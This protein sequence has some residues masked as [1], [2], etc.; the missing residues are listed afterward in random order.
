MDIFLRFP[1]HLYMHIFLK[2]KYKLLSNVK[3]YSS[4]N[5]I[6]LL[7]ML[8]A[9][10]ILN[11]HNIIFSLG[12]TVIFETQ[13][14]SLYCSESGSQCSCSTILLLGE[15]W[16]RPLLHTA[17]LKVKARLKGHYSLHCW[18]FAICTYYTVDVSL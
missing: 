5:S 2:L 16:S 1:H 4:H 6:R 3:S 8:D 11:R 7:E 13:K 12:A 15:C 18:C 17:F 14:E 10:E 9:E